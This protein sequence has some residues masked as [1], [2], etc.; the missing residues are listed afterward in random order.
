MPDYAPQ[1]S[2]RCVN[3]GN[4]L[5]ELLEVRFRWREGCSESYIERLKWSVK[6]TQARF[7]LMAGIFLLN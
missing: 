5:S 4:Y 6:A 1:V 3:D 7:D 2:R